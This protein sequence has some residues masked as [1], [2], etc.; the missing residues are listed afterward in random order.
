LEKRSDNDSE[1]FVRVS[2][3]ANGLGFSLIKLVIRDVILPPNL[4]KAFA[5]VLETKREAQRKLEEAPGEHAVLR[6][7]A[8]APALF[9]QN[10]MLHQTRL[11]QAL[12]SSNNSVVLNVDGATVTAKPARSAS[13]KLKFIQTRST[14]VCCH[15]V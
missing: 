4:K 7:L 9:Q 3:E 13:K 11:M 10:P 2:E 6:K 12:S 14:A 5:G 8:N 15:C 1:I